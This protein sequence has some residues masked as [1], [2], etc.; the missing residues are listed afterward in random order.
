M[1]QQQI[2]ESRLTVSWDRQI[3]SGVVSFDSHIFEHYI[4]MYHSD[5]VEDNQWFAKYMDSDMWI[6]QE[7]GLYFMVADDITAIVY[8]CLLLRCGFTVLAP[9]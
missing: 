7:P 1:T 4:C 3:Y 2:D 9:R 5:Q 8:A 6:M